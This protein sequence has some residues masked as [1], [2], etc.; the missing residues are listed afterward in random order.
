MVV[1]A[2]TELSAVIWNVLA[3]YAAAIATMASKTEV[4][5]P[6]RAL[7]HAVVGRGDLLKEPSNDEDV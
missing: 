5:I 6:N 7:V 4:V 1:H 3:V 2:P